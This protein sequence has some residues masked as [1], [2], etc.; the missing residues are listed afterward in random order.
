MATQDTSDATGGTG[1]QAQIELAGSASLDDPDVF[2][3]SFPSLAPSR[4]SEAF[5]LAEPVVEEP[6]DTTPPAVS[7]FAP[8]TGPIQKSTPI[9]F[10]VTDDSGNFARIMVL[11]EFGDGTYEVIHD[12]V[13]FATSYASKS[14]R[15]V[16]TDGYRYTVERLGGWTSSSMTIRAIGIDLNGNVG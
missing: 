7:N 11:V 15:K 10:D 12:G 5:L 16:I 9:S 6:E 14:S 13:K 1:P 2:V 4:S 8:A 3:S